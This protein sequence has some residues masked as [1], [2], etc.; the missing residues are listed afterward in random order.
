[1]VELLAQ[2]DGGWGG[3]RRVG[4]AGRQRRESLAMGLV[5]LV[6]LACL[7]GA[8]LAAESATYAF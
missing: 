1:M 2:S 8:I 4:V 6:G 3:G 5:A 7:G